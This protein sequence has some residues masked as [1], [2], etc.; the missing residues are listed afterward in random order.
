MTSL[1]RIWS[2]LTDISPRSFLT[3]YDQSKF[4]GKG[5]GRLLINIIQVLSLLRHTQL[6]EEYSI[7]NKP[8]FQNIP[9]RNNLYH[10]QKIKL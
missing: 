3:N 9:L 7:T 1:K 6:L 5:I 2:A 8:Y 4:Q 10:H